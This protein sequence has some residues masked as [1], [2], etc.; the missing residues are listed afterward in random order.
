MSM[1]YTLYAI[2][3]YNVSE[4]EPLF[5]VYDNATHPEKGICS[6]LNTLNADDKFTALPIGQVGYGDSFTYGSHSTK[7][8]ETRK[9][10]LLVKI[11]MSHNK[12]IKIIKTNIDGETLSKY[13]AILDSEITDTNITYQIFRFRGEFQR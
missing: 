12:P 4:I 11:D 13:K 6:Y 10:E 1:Y 9:I 8:D 7:D 3:R 2:F 5:C